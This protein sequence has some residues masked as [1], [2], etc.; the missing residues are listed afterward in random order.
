MTCQ[1]CTATNTAESR[2]CLSCGSA[3]PVVPAQ[4]EAPEAVDAATAQLVAAAA[5]SPS[6]T[7][8]AGTAGESPLLDAPRAAFRTGDRVEL[9]NDIPVDAVGRGVPAGAI[10]IVLGT[11]VAGGVVAHS[12]DFTVDGGSLVRMVAEDKLRPASARG[13]AAHVPPAEDTPA[14]TGNTRTT[15][16]EQDTGTAS[17]STAEQV[18][19]R[20]DGSPPDFK[21]WNFLLPFLVYKLFFSA[22]RPLVVQTTITAERLHALFAEVLNGQST[23]NKLAALSN[24]YTRNA[25]WTLRRMSADESLAVCQPKGLV[26]W[27]AGR[28]KRLCDIS[29]DSITVTTVTT[30]SGRVVATIGPSVFTTVFGVFFA[31]PQMLLYPRAVVKRWKQEDPG[32]LIAH[33]ISRSRMAVWAV[34]VLLLLSSAVG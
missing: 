17:R 21:G 32:L 5:A 12:I 25:R 9:R 20:P 6:N 24:S 28:F 3:L 14:P 23:L 26:M 1:D 27:G 19:A 8:D 33:P 31:F 2:Y 30:S 7:V 4:V 22:R 11:D 16:P 29:D 15:V 18:R 13:F 34:L 10:G